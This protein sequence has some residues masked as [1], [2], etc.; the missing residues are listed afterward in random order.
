MSETKRLAKELMRLEN[1]MF[2]VSDTADTLAQAT[3]GLANQLGL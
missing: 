2:S 1:Q 3:E